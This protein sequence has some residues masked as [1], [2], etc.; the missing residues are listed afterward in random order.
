[1]PGYGTT[2]AFPSLVMQTENPDLKENR[3]TILFE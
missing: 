3:A 2:A 1:M